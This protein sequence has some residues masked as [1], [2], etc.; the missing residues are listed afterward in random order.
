[1]PYFKDLAE[2]ELIAREGYA[3]LGLSLSEVKSFGSNLLG[4]AK[5]LYEGTQQAKGREQAYKELATKQAAAP[6]AST[7][8]WVLP[9]AIG[10]T[11]LVA[12][13]LL[14]KK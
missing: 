1:M 2:E 8:S 13:L 5:S 11:A 9:V 6:A 10:G 12:F 4:Q 3:G 7:P 14:R